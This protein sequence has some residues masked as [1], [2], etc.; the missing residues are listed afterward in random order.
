MSA[1]DVINEAYVDWWSRDDDYLP[2]DAIL[3]ALTVD[4]WRVVRI[5][6]CECE[7]VYCTAHGEAVHVIEE[8][9]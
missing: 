8:A 7:D 4:G 3:T 1:Q 2:A 9:T 6:R 5:K